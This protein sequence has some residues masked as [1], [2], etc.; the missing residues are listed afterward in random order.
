MT[1]VASV[2][3]TSVF[4]L[5]LIARG[6]P[7]WCDFGHHHGDLSDITD[8]FEDD[9]RD[10]AAV[11]GGG[12]MDLVRWIWRDSAAVVGGGGDAGDG[13]GAVDGAG[14]GSFSKAKAKAR[15]EG[16]GGKGKGRGQRQGSRSR[17]DGQRQRRPCYC[18]FCIWRATASTER[19]CY[20]Y[21]NCC[22]CRHFHE[23]ASHSSPFVSF[24]QRRGSRASR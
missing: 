23:L 24:M 2:S 17:S 11:V 9:D 18:C 16:R 1:K 6:F 3:R 19:F 5:K 13:S 21:D 10:S 8:H 7:P 14:G 22:F 12:A 4:V 20:D 15:V